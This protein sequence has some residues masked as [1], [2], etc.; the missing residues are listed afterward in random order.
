MGQGDPGEGHSWHDWKGLSLEVGEGMSPVEP[1]GQNISTCLKPLDSVS[2]H[3]HSPDSRQASVLLSGALK[4]IF[5][6]SLDPL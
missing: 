6:L 5:L 3:L 1:E 2:S 4:G